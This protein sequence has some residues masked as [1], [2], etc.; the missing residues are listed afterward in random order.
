MLYTIENEHIKARIASLGAELKSLQAVSDGKEFLW[1]PGS[2]FWPGQARNLFPNVGLPHRQRFVIGG[3]EFPA[4][5]HGFAKDMEF[6]LVFHHKDKVLFR[7]S[8]NQESH[9]YYPFAFL[10][11]IEFELCGDELVQ[12][13]RVINTGD[14]NLPF[15]LGAHTGFYC[16]ID[17]QEKPED[18]YL[19]FSEPEQP[20][21]IMVSKQNLCTGEELPYNININQIKLREDFFTGAII[22]KNIKSNSI[23]LRSKK[24]GRFVTVRFGGFPYL[25]IWS[26]PEQL[27]FLCIE[28]WCG[29]PDYHDAKYDFYNKPGIVTIQANEV[30]CLEQGF[31]IG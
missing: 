7:L 29:L 21:Q 17:A 16:P 9:R 27:Y 22:L 3:K 11:E 24:S 18:Y 23:S 12:R 13:Y 26:K 15:S 30:F 5:Q 19:E 8:D 31:R 6:D 4:Q 1:Q 10:F 20:V 14:T 28:P 25:T 2:E